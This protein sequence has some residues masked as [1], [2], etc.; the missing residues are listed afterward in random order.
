MT[1]TTDYQ[2]LAQFW[3]MKYL[4]LQQHTTQVIMLLSRP[5]VEQIKASQQ[6]NPE[7][8]ANLSATVEGM[9]SKA[10]P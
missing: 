10:K 6:I 4:E 1:D 3:Q 5:A 7:A 8:V 9:N 2:K